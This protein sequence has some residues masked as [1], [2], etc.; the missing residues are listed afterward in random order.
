MK[1]LYFLFLLLL[2]SCGGHD[3]TVDVEEPQAPKYP[4]GT[5]CANVDYYNPSTGTRRTYTLNVE[6]ESNEVTTILFG[7]GGYLDNSH[8]TPESLS[9]SGSCSITDDK[10]RTF[11]ISINGSA[12]A[13]IDNINDGESV[14]EETRITLGQCAATIPMT[15]EELSE[16]ETQFNAS[17]NESISEGFCEKLFDY[18]T[19][20]REIK[21]KKDDMERQMSNGYIQ[22]LHS[23]G[24]DDNVRCQLMIV[25]RNGTYYLLELAGR[26]RATMGLTDFDPYSSDWQNIAI[27]E[28]FESTTM[29]V[30]EARV[31]NRSSSMASLES[32]MDNYCS[33]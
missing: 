27:K 24:G 21:R 33:F 10:N 11:D 12:C 22:K 18:V 31:I 14:A 26:R 2:V 15:E 17:R 9:N 28:N 7:N 4:D 8:I 13:S 16:Y 30:F 32:E 1:Y 23:I 29:L 6:V 19:K 25:L 5:Y 3:T 20:T